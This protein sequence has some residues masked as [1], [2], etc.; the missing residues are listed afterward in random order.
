MAF[1]EPNVF[2]SVAIHPD[3]SQ[4]LTCGT[5]HKVTYWDVTDGQAIREL[6]GG[7]DFMNCIDM[8]ANGEFYL[9]GSDDKLLKLWHYDEGLTVA[10]GKGHSGAINC[11][12]MS[13]DQTVLVSAGRDGD[14]IFWRCPSTAQLRATA[15]DILGESDAPYK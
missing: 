2:K 11:A 8:D 10:K 7:D 4:I 15:S 3:E 12:A 5:N 14:V 13:P 1:F 6:E 9:T